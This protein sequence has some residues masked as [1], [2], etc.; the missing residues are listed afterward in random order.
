MILSVISIMLAV[1]AIGYA[2]HVAVVYQRFNDGIKDWA[3][4][5]DESARAAIDRQSMV[6]LKELDDKLTDLQTIKEE[7]DD[8]EMENDVPCRED[9]ES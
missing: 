4:A 9:A 3:K 8:E 1:L 5:L 7:Y 2:A 6:I